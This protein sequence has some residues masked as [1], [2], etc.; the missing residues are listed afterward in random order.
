[1]RCKVIAVVVAALVAETVVVSRRRGSLLNFN[2]VVR[3][4]SGHL[5]TT[6]WVPGASVT[7]LRLGLWRLQ[8]CPV[9]NHWSMVSPVRVSELTEEERQA[10]AQ[11]H[12]A[13][14]P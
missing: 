13:R 3:C 2:T 5:F 10:A 9:G 1:M 6:L 14:L 11:V 7:S 12:D 4:R 8:R